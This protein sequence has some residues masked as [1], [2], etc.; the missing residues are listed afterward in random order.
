MD[1]L[2]LIVRYPAALIDVIETALVFLVALGL[3][4]TDD[5]V[6]NTTGV[7]IA[8]AAV[9][10]ALTVQPW[11]VNVF[12]DA[13][14]ALAV[15]AVGFGWLDWDANT[16]AIFV[17]LVGTA[18]TMFN[19][20]QTTPVYDPVVAAGGAGAGPVTGKSGDDEAGYTALEVVGAVL[21]LAGLVLLI[22]TL[23]VESVHIGIVIPLVLLVI[24][25][26]ILAVGRTRV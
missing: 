13:A 22:L 4:W 10:K 19:T 16:T 9:A 7:V 5:Q 8:V 15:F 24:G 17:T 25:V 26:V 3:N 2:K 18:V 12:T 20:T 1:R 21:A 23:A 14:R 6:A 11:P